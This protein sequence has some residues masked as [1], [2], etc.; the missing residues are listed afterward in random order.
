MILLRGEH[1]SLETCEEII[2]IWIKFLNKST[3]SI[4]CRISDERVIYFLASLFLVLIIEPNWIL[5]TKLSFQ[6]S[7][8]V[9]QIISH[10]LQNTSNRSLKGLPFQMT[11]QPE[12]ILYLSFS[13]AIQ[14]A[15]C[16]I[17]VQVPSI[18][19]WKSSPFNYCQVIDFRY[20]DLVVEF[21]VMLVIWG[22]E[23]AGIHIVLVC[24]AARTKTT[25]FRLIPFPFIVIFAAKWEW[26]LS[27]FRVIKLQESWRCRY[28][29]S[30]K[31][32]L[33]SYR[34]AGVSK[35]SILLFW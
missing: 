11:L 4:I 31:N 10:F 35:L 7:R 14:S 15:N 29:C 23:N 19:K 5:K 22:G 9:N 26:M 16:R 21:V 8:F 2:C 18:S 28:Y 30:D 17:F 24:D 33:Q 6:H 32:S 1:I 13:T 25:V 3:C 12:I 34:L 27:Y 20:I